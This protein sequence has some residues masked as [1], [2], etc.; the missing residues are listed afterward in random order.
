MTY[1]STRSGQSITNDS[2]LFKRLAAIITDFID[3][4]Y[5]KEKL[6]INSASQDREYVN[7]KSTGHIGF[8]VYPIDSWSNDKIAKEKLFDTIE[9]FYKF[10]SKPGEY[11]YIKDHTNWDYEDYLDYNEADGK[12]EYRN[13]VNILL[14]AYREG[15]ELDDKGTILFVG[16]ET[17]NFI[18]TDF[19]EYNDQNIDSV[20]HL[21][22]KQWRNKDQSLEEK[23]QAIVKLANVF[24]YLKKEKTL[25]KVLDKKDSSDLFQIANNFALRHH[26]PEQKSNYDP[27]IWYDWIF[28]Y[29]LSTCIATLKL[30]KKNKP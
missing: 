7:T 9:F 2:E 16:D 24:E 20:I 27:E 30:I 13:E 14:G 8:R 11:G 18:D 21:A 3:R 6:R 17:T 19:P 22:I 29:Y 25:E 12:N 4:D 5:F 26:N 1:Y 23:K 15:Y 10:I 28:Q